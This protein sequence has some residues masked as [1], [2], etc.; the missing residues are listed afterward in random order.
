[1]FLKK[2]H[3]RPIGHAILEHNTRLRKGLVS[4]FK[5]N[6]IIAFLKMWM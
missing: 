6:K 2:C 5:N 1:M 3:S 4:Y